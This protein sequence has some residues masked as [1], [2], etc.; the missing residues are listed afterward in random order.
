M[1]R[2]ISKVENPSNL[3]AVHQ[4]AGALQTVLPINQ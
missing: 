1:I 3:A 4:K 2:D